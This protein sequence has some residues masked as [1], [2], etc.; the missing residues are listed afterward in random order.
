MFR[1]EACTLAPLALWH[2]GTSI[3]MYDSVIVAAARTPTGKFLGALKHLKATEL[4]AHVVR[5]A[6][7]RAGIDPGIVDECI[8]GNV[9]QAG[10]GQNPADRR[11]STAACTNASPPSPSTRS[12]APD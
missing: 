4:G 8:M 12:A 2:P 9:L 3:F 10:N 6:V 1:A 11:R 7:V 5:E